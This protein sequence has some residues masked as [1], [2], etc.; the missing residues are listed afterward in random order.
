MKPNKELIENKRKAN[1]AKFAWA[2]EGFDS[3][4]KAFGP[5]K[6]IKMIDYKVKE[7]SVSIVLEYLYMDLF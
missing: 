5:L 6:I 2:T 4:N 1:R 3:L 7:T